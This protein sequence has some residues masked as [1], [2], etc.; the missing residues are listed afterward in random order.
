MRSQAY[1][2]ISPLIACVAMV[3]SSGLL[4][5]CISESAGTVVYGLNESDRDVIVASSHHRVAPRILT[6]HTWG[7]LFDDYG[8]PSGE[9]TVFDLD[10]HPLATLPLTRAID[11]LLIGRHEEVGFTGGLIGPVPSGVN[12]APPNANGDGTFWAEATCP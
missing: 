6:A 5:S 9:I 1:S 4:S 2:V 8:H 11:T 12:G 3:A 7:R 10:C